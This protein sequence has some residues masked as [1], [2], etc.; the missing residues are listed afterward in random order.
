MTAV[1]ENQLH[2]MQHALGLDRYGQGS[3]YR[4]YFTSGPHCDGWEELNGLVALGLM[5]RHEPR[6]ITGGLHC[7]TVTDLG[8]RYVA[9][10]SEKPPKLTRSQVRYRE[11]LNADTGIPFGEWLKGTNQ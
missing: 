6:E 8:G 2:Y 1:S 3:R 5:K 11:W 9:A 4:N 7:F 10:H